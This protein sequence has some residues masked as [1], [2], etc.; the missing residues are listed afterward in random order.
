[1]VQREQDGVGDGRSEEELENMMA[2][3][4]QDGDGRLLSRG[5]TDLGQASCSDAAIRE[6]RAP[7][8]AYVIHAP[9]TR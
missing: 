2:V 3:R 9:S 1:M 6:T 4:Q 7:Q 5:L 8:S